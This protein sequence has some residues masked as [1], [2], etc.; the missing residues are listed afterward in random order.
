MSTST[1]L[2][3][4]WR[5][6]LERIRNDQLQDL[7]INWHIFKQL[8]EC[9]TP[10]VGTM[11]G[12]E[13]SRWMV[14][15]YVAFS[16]TA[17]RRVIETPRRTPNP[18]W[19]SI[20]LVILL[21]DMAKNDSVLTRSRFR[22]LYGKS[23]AI[24]FADRDFNRISRNKRASQISAQRIRRDIGVIDR[25]CS[26]IKRLADKVVAH[27][28]EDRRRIGRMK[29]GQIDRAV[30]VLIDTFE[31]YSLLVNGSSCDLLESLTRVNVRSDFKKLW[32]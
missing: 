31:R 12:A 14:Q 11:H 1:I 27:T 22:G 7:V 5:R 9:T 8:Q 2:L 26:P 4:K 3:R 6:W 18:D 13:L 32:P 24:H 17:I 10:Y 30:K 16:V 21:D 15:N 28:E 25:T 23:I 20:S 29:Y 19:R